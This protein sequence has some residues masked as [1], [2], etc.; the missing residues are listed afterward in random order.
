MK[1]CQKHTKALRKEAGK[2]NHPQ[3]H[4]LG[5]TVKSLVYF[6]A[7]ILLLFNVVV[8][9]RLTS[10]LPPFPLNIEAKVF[11]YVILTSSCPDFISWLKKN[12]E[13]YFPFCMSIDNIIAR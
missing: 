10:L 4:I 3:S 2:N 5:K 7:W 11:P 1:E 8:I 9:L 6:L 13:S 12:V